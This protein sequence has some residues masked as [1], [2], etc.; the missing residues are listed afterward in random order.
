[1]NI[2]FCRSK[3]IRDSI[4]NTRSK[5]F[6]FFGNRFIV[7]MLNRFW[8]QRFCNFSSFSCKFFSY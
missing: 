5:F 3:F 8:G 4:D 2:F 6:F 1:M 7:Y